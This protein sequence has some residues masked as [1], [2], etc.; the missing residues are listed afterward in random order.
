MAQVVLFI[1][2]WGVATRIHAALGV[3]ERLI[4]KSQRDFLGAVWPWTLAAST[5]LFLVA[6]ETAV[7]GYVPG[8]SDQTELQHICWKILAL[9]LSLFLTSVCSGFACDLEARRSV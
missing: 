3:W 6:L 8:V 4:P 2:T 9:A 7:F 1:L 5:L